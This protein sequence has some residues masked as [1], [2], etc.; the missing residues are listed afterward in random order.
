MTEPNHPEAIFQ[1]HIANYLQN[2]LGY[3]CLESDE[4][5]DKEFYIAEELFFA[6]IKA[7]Q[8]DGLARLELNYGSDSLS[9][10]LKALK[11][12]L[13]LKPLWLIMRDGLEV[14][15]EQFKLFY[16]KPRSSA[17]VANLYYRE[18]RFQF[19]TE[20][21]IKD[22]ERP[23][24]VL[25]LNGLPIV[26]IELKHEK[27]GQSVH[28]AVTQFNNRNHADKIFQLPFLY[29]AVDTTDIKVATNPKEK[30]FFRW[31]N[32]G[33]INEAQ[34]DGEY[35]VEFFYR[36]VLAKDNLL[37]A[38]SF[39]LVYVPEQGSRPSYSL[40]PRY[41]QSR[42]VDKLSDDISAHFETTGNVGKKYLVNHSAGS[43]KTL[44]I[45]WLAERLHSLYQQDSNTKL[46]DMVFVLTDRKD[47]DKN[48]R[49]ELE[50]FKHL[51]E[52]MVFAKK[53]N[54]LSNYITQRKA[55]IVTTIQKF[56]VIF[57]QL[58]EDKSLQQYRVAFLIDEAHRS[59]EGKNARAIRQPFQDR[60]IEGVEEAEDE[61]EQIKKVLEVEAG[62]QLFVAFT[63]TPTQAT[64]NLFGEPFDIYSEAEAIAEG[65]IIDVAA[66]IISYETLYQLHSPLS[67]NTSE[68][69]RLYP[70]G[71]ISK[72]LKQVAFEDDGLI[73]YKAEVMLRT[74]EEQVK[75]LINGK[76]KM[77]I[78]TS[79][80]LAGLKYFD[81][82]QEKIKQKQQENPTQYNYKVLYAFSDFVN[83]NNNEEVKE[84]S[85]NKLNSGER[86]E[87]RFKQ[88][89]YRILVVASKFQTG[90]DEP[91]LAGMCLDKPV[92]DKNAV[93]TLSRLNRCYDGKDKVI[94]LDFTNNT[95]NIIKAFNKYRKGTPYENSTPNKEKVIS[96]YQEIIDCG[97]FTDIDAQQLL[98]LLAAGN[99]ANTQSEINRY[100]QR[101]NFTYEKAEDRRTY[102]Y[103]L[104]NLVKAFNFLSSFYQ[105]SEEIERFILFA[106]FVQLQL[107]KEGSESELMADIRKV[108]LTRAAIKFHGETVFTP[109]VVKKIAGRGGNN[110]PK[111]VEKT[112]IDVAIEELKNRYQISDEEAL[113]I[114]EVCEEKQSDQTILSQ[115]QC[116]KDK[117]HYLDAVLKSEIR[118][119]IEEAFEQRGHYAETCDIKYIDTGAIFDIMAHSVLMHGLTI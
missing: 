46:V 2:R 43:G 28:D 99:D 40:F 51:S 52:Q 62:N 4:I 31:Y 69:E 35:P 50:C 80:R 1:K 75:P 119:S 34:N 29:A 27:G 22:D 113:I 77:M 111:P 98:K 100:R 89:D 112:T 49:D 74:F 59:Q 8:K 36:N 38:L 24:I 81:I 39:F 44:T 95:D 13:Q 83:P 71:I 37:K 68:D 45:S 6:F 70:K 10:I 66:Q 94:V 107:I 88:E 48:V 73:Q 116:N 103:K 84:H 109:E 91:L 61:L 12:E 102:V 21:V 14:R 15:G 63:A 3:T 33:L 87:E 82:L 92:I 110:T 118:V 20:L 23:D 65:Y 90:F 60:V 30:A 9:E 32:A 42:L 64:V 115:I 67:L 56:G 114:R 105:Y 47:L 108:V 58:R 26:V 53:S 25:F 11:S 117:Q 78:V 79:S 86:I 97:L 17:S 19:K 57:K 72:L 101:F 18:N 104:A 76:A 55:I 16:P 106:E 54:E 93:Q 96:I 5:S 85:L 7:T 41:H